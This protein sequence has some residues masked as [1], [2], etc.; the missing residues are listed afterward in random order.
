[1]PLKVKMLVASMLLLIGC[2]SKH[3]PAPVVGV[4]IL[5][6]QAGSHAPFS[7]MLFSPFYLENYL[8]WKDTNK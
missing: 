3:P 4:D 5:S 6:V 8:Q 1:M 2:A 7:G